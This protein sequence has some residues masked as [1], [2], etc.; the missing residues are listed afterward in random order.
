MYP[1]DLG[2][3]RA[4]HL[5]SLTP[6][7][8]EI[9]SCGRSPKSRSDEYFQQLR[10]STG[11]PPN[12]TSWLHP[13]L[14]DIARTF[15]EMRSQCLAKSFLAACLPLAVATSTGSPHILYRGGKDTVAESKSS[16]QERSGLAENA[17]SDAICTNQPSS[18]HCWNEGY[19]IDTDVDDAWP[20]T[21]RTI[22]VISTT[23][24]FFFISG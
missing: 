11:Q 19:D 16:L 13:Y 3:I 9:S 2:V 24:T 21:G 12:A 1:W 18:R 15:T 20:T 6:C 7:W 14:I 5:K 8:V 10:L 23:P 22:Y 17:V 4:R